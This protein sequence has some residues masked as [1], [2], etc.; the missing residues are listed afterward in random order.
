MYKS[1]QE[2]SSVTYRLEVNVAFKDADF[3]A[4]VTK[5]WVNR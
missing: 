2:C 1:A 5:K 4:D 3:I